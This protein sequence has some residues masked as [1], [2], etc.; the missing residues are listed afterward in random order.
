MARGEFFLQIDI[1][2]NFKYSRGIH[3][4][5]SLMKNVGKWLMSNWISK[6]DEQDRTNLTKIA[7]SSSLSNL[8]WINVP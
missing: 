7:L 1:W 6:S 5:E 8:F 3:N 4:E 2:I